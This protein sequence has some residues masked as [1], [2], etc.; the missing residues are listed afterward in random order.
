MCGSIKSI[1]NENRECGLTKT[2]VSMFLGDLPMTLRSEMITYS[3]DEN[4][5]LEKR[6][7]DKTKA[8]T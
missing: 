5:L 1:K 3:E 6:Q 2:L 4:T 7:K 8:T